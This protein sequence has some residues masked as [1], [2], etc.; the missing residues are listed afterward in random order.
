MPVLKQI[1]NIFLL[2]VVL[3]SHA[4][5]NVFMPFRLD[6]GFLSA[7]DR[8]ALKDILVSKR[9]VA[10]GE[11]TYGT[12]E[13]YT[14]KTKLVQFLVQECGFRVFAMETFFSANL[15]NDY[16]NGR[17]HDLSKVM[18]NLYT[19]YHAQ[20]FV[21]LLRWFKE[22]NQSV[23]AAQRVK[24]YG[25]DSEHMDNLFG[26]LTA[27]VGHVDPLYIRECAEKLQI[28]QE[29]LDPAKRKN[30]LKSIDEV[31]QHVRDWKK[32]YVLLSSLAQW[33]WADKILEVMRS[34]VLQSAVK[35]RQSPEVKALHDE[36]MANNV[37][38][39]SD[40]AGENSKVI[41]WAH[42]KHIQKAG[43]TGAKESYPRMGER[44]RDFFGEAYYVVGFDF[45]EGSFNAFDRTGDSMMQPCYVFNQH[46]ESA[47]AIVGRYADNF[48]V[49][50]KHA[51]HAG[52]QHDLVRVQYIRE[53]GMSF[54]GDQL[55][56]VAVAVQQAFDALVYIKT[57]TPSVFVDGRKIR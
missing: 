39:I 32:E 11:A 53:C 24:F 41:V 28:L 18:R 46:P 51:A 42:N 5:Q 43:R 49:D 37:K 36:A 56:F 25:I 17:Q 50:L 26:Q 6:S 27:Y 10:L 19:V 4:Q 1:L 33:Q 57:T 7:D 40:Y 29:Q 52:V 20:E 44:L 9:I 54:S 12:H 38:W 35:D 31:H 3:Q 22:Y 8:Q 23:P 45:G 55:T 34:A 13:F 47:T 48:F 14:T 15:L 30:Y 21:E 2:I 16:I